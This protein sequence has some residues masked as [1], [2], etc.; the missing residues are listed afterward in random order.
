MPWAGRRASDFERVTCARAFC[1]REYEFY[2]AAPRDGSAP[3]SQLGQRVPRL[4][5]PCM[6]AASLTTCLPPSPSPSGVVLSVGTSLSRVA[7]LRLA[8]RAQ[9]ARC[10][11][12]PLVLA[13]LVLRVP[14]ASQA[15][16]AKHVCI[17]R[18]ACQSAQGLG[19][20]GGH[21]AHAVDAAS[22]HVHLMSGLYRGTE[23]EHG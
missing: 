22:R 10:C 9:L 12:Q 4:S 21:Q 18:A 8:A 23:T 16:R 19:R 3:T 13:Q 17:L 11:A 7:Q 2:R 5:T 15:R 6:H 1:F 14:P 20:V